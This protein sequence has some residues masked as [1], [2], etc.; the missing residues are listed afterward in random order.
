MNGRSGSVMA[1]AATYLLLHL[2]R[3]PSWKFEGYRLDCLTLRMKALK[4]FELF[5]SRCSVTSQKTLKLQ[6]QC[7]K[8]LKP[9][10]QIISSEGSEMLIFKILS[11]EM[12]RNTT[13]AH[14]TFTSCNFGNICKTTEEFSSW[15]LGQLYCTCAN[16]VLSDA[17]SC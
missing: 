4:F 6:Q 17:V 5:T 3:R 13:S 2:K 12:L 10:L 14:T 7:C 9:R 16:C 1:S 11:L 8:N 15:N